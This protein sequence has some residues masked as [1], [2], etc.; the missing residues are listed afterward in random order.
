[1]PL[2]K[3]LRTPA[4]NYTQQMRMQILQDHKGLHDLWNESPPLT[5]QFSEKLNTLHEMTVM[6]LKA[7]GINHPINDSLDDPL[8]RE[9][10]K[11]MG[12]SDPFPEP[13]FGF[14]GTLREDNDRDPVGTLWSKGNQFILR[15][16]D[17]DALKAWD[18]NTKDVFC[19]D[20]SDS[21]N[22][23]T[24]RMRKPETQDEW[25]WAINASLFDTAYWID[26][27]LEITKVWTEEAR[28]A[29]LETR[30]RR[31]VDQDA[32]A[33]LRRERVQPYPQAGLKKADEATK[34]ISQGSPTDYAKQ[35]MASLPA[36]D[37]DNS[38]IDAIIVHGAES[39]SKFASLAYLTSKEGGVLA[40]IP[41][42]VTGEKRGPEAGK[43]EL[44]LNGSASGKAQRLAILMAVGRQQLSNLDPI[45]V[46]RVYDLFHKDRAGFSSHYMKAY[47]MYATGEGSRAKLEAKEPVIHDYFKYHF[48]T[49]G[50]SLGNAI[51]IR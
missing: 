16:S 23:L 14:V 15:S 30:R 37:I 50:K 17:R 5:A 38:D 3:L 26:S 31:K 18:E 6:K 1:M 11:I 24:I 29:S 46:R 43:F 44:H 34:Y 48:G 35:V 33:K 45:E 40:L 22:G 2:D 47:T 12:N 49:S 4:K 39:W 25:L 32:I 20:L 28:A 13:G 51:F 36:N 21:E 27:P 9:L 41:R 10:E 8:L 7:L 19:L 42:S